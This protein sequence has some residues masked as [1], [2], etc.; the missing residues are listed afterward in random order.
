MAG[1]IKIHRD[2]QRH[3]IA[4]DFTRLGWWVD[5]L[6]LANCEDSRTLVG[7]RLVDVKRGQMVVSYSYLAK[8]WKS[9]KSVVVSFISLLEANTMIERFSERK[10]TILTICNYDSYILE[11]MV[12]KNDERTMYERYATDTLPISNRSTVQLSNCDSGGYEGLKNDDE[13]MSN[14]CGYQRQEGPLS[15]PSSFSPTPPFIT[16]PIIPQEENKQTPRTYERASEETVT[17]DADREQGYVATFT[18]Q[19]SALPFSKKVG[20][21]PQEV[22]QLLDVYM[23]TRELKNLGH[24]D[25]S[26]FINLFIWHVENNK[27]SVPAKPEVKKEPKVISGSDIYNVYG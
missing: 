1:W 19:G 15:S 7:N 14:R 6:F 26:A 16:P 8:R 2:F 5:L 4:Q 25:Y 20:K 11:S 13:T 22:M 12:A 24:K 18:G 10:L 9:T 27:V 17:W 3:W 23:A 21:S